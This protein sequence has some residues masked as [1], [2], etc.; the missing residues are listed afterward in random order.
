VLARAEADAWEDVLSE[1]LAHQSETS[2]SEV[3][4]LLGIKVDR[5]DKPTQIR[6]GLA[7][8][9]LG[10]EKRRVRNGRVLT[11]IYERTP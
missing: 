10:W 5:L 1:K 11:Y 2:M 3:S 4:T 6:L 7:M 8:Q 9:A